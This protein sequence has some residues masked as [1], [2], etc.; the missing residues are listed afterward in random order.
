MYIIAET[1]D[2]TSAAC[3]VHVYTHRLRKFNIG[4]MHDIDNTVT[5][6]CSSLPCFVYAPS[7]KYRT[8]KHFHWTKFRPT[9]LPLHA[10][11]IQK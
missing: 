11:Y 10:L 8:A 1:G 3:D 7:L 9:Q 2:S 4:F 6:L 5:S